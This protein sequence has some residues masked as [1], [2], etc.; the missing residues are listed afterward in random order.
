MKYKIHKFALA[1][2]EMNPLEYSDLKKDLKENGQKVPIIIY[3]NEILD[4]RHRYKA[5]TELKVEPKINSFKGTEVEAAKLVISLNVK[6]RH[7]SRGQATLLGVD[8]LLPAIQKAA[9]EKQVAAVVSGNKSRHIASSSKNRIPGES[10]LTNDIVGKAVGASAATVA[11]G[12]KIAKIASE[13]EEAADIVNEVR[14]GTKSLSK[15]Y[16]E[17]VKPMSKVA[18][19]K[20]EATRRLLRREE[21][22]PGLEKFKR[23]VIDGW[24]EGNMGL[25]FKTYK[26]FIDVSDQ[27]TTP[28]RKRYAEQFCK[29]GKL[30]LGIPSNPNHADE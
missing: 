26:D 23:F 3:N 14:A 28:Q 7:L 6:R 11:M 5:L 4:G 8:T 20:L 1:V 24:P 25:D 18:K 21:Q 19:N 16:N 30:W 2:P 12:V 29:L 22:H 9:K 13:D 17:I 27:M 15:A 10:V